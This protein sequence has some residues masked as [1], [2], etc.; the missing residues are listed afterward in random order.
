MV[1]LHHYRQGVG[2]SHDVGR[3]AITVARMSLGVGCLVA[4]LAV[5]STL[6]LI[7]IGVPLALV[8][9]ALLVTDA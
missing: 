6:V 4:G 2:R 9:V 7:P 1:N 5:T 3:M 8:G